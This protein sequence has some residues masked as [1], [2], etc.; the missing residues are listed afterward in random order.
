MPSSMYWYS[1]MLAA[2]IL[3]PST[4]T[5][6]LANDFSPC[7]APKT[8][9]SSIFSG[10]SASPPIANV[11]FFAASTMYLRRFG[12]DEKVAPEIASMIFS[13]SSFSTSSS[14]AIVFP[15]TKSV[16]AL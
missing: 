11:L 9:L 5:T 4:A 3:S 15:F 8:Y 16:T 12:V 10:F 6:A 14:S 2:T 1:S 7:G 13:S